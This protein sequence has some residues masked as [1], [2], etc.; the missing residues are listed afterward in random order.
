MS[1][2]LKSFKQRKSL[3]QIFL[4]DNWPCRKLV[5]QLKALHVDEV[6]EI[7][8]GAGI[9]TH[10]LLTE[11][12]KVTAVEKDEQLIEHLHDLGRSLGAED[13]LTIINQDILKFSLPEWVE[14]NNAKKAVCGNIPYH[15]STPIFT[16]IL[17][18]LPKIQGSL[19]MTQLEFAER[20]AAPPNNKNYGS[21]SVYGQLRSNIRLSFT[22]PRSCFKP[23]PKVDSAVVMITPRSDAISDERLEQVEA[24]TRRAFSMRRKMLSNSLAPL[25]EKTEQREKITFDLSRRCDSLSPVEYVEL[26]KQ[27][28][29]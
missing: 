28:F 9:L 6:V 13:R 23:V 15:I 7:G 27:V 8:P 17:E 3:S 5:E 26:A 21:L 16:Q 20:L 25:L 14:H 22:V 10:V 24:I 1:K 4:R 11:G 12:L 18:V 29:G 2:H 19:L